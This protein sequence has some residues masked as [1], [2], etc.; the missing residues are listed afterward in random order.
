L[1]FREVGDRRSEAVTALNLANALRDT[2]NLSQAAD[3]YGEALGEFVDAGDHQDV[4]LVFLGLGGVMAGVGQ[5][6]SAAKLLAAA[7][8]LKPGEDLNS[9]EKSREATNLKANISAIRSALGEEGFTAAW[10]AGRTMSLDA[11]VDVALSSAP[12]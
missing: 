6:E 9:T 4:A 11:A 12:R 3:Q 1:L 7:S 8:V 5:F 10:D 2:G